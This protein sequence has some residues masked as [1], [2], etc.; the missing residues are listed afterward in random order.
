MGLEAMAQAAQALLGPGP[1][2]A[3]EHLQLD[4]A[5]V[6]PDRQS[7]TIRL[8]ALMTSPGVVDVALRSSETN[9]AV[10]HFKAR[11][12]SVD[13]DLLAASASELAAE[14]ELDVA[15]TI[16]LYGAL[17][18][19]QG[20][21]RR[22]RAYR[23]LSS[24]ECVAEIEEESR[25]SWFG[26][27][28][29]QELLLCDPAGRDAAIHAIQAC[30]PHERILPSAVERVLISRSPRADGPLF[31]SA[32][33][34]RKTGES[35]VYDVDITDRD[36]KVVERWEGL[37]LR[38]MGTRGPRH[39]PAAWL[40]PFFERRLPELFPHSDL[41]LFIETN[42]GIRHTSSDTM[43]SKANSNSHAIYRRSDGKLEAQGPLRS[44]ASHSANLTV[45]AT[46]LGTL[47]CDVE[48]VVDRP[49]WVD[50]LG[51]ERLTLAEIVSRECHE[52]ISVAGTRIWAA[53]ECLTKAAAPIDSPLQYAGVT[54]DGWV[55][56]TSG[57]SKIATIEIGLK[58][59]DKPVI[60]AVLGDGKQRLQCELMNTATR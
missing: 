26:R 31:A 19:H 22:V 7:V 29:S 9:F 60:L 25:M 16:D 43:L 33:E 34:R 3:F 50:L 48:E 5:V 15:P 4:R 8:A 46:G 24:T 35:F 14:E 6:I 44:C 52:P 51:A 56:L 32:V 42:G 49:L 40:R 37:T 59:L 2:L 36:G 30:L 20:R 57:Q 45:V 23:R 27:N 10:D 58:E 39:W 41:K 53:G 47:A 1:Q 13:G 12:R 18:F 11:C 17:L 28:H 54:N 21:F 38:R 55:V